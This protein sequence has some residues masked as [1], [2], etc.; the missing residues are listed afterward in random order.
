MT[1]YEFLATVLKS[2]CYSTLSDLRHVRANFSDVPKDTSLKSRVIYTAA[3]LKIAGG[4]GDASFRPDE[5]ISRVEALAILLRASDIAPIHPSL[6]KTT[7]AFEDVPSYQW[8]YPYVYTAV[9][10][11]IVGGYRDGTFRP[12]KHLT[13]AEGAKLVH[14]LMQTDTEPPEQLTSAAPEEPI[15]KEIIE[16]DL[17]D[18]VEKVLQLQQMATILSQVTTSE[19]LEAIEQTIK[20]EEI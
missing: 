19:D 2:R 10:E 14:S 13:R 11:G 9:Y 12:A 20:E 8:Y 4:N 7:N 15:A 3:H 18:P 5:P 1:R 6:I 16:E 17:V